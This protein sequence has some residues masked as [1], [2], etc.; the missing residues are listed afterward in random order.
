MIL[1]A[2]AGAWL[3][4]RIVFRAINLVLRLLPRV[5]RRVRPWLGRQG[6]R[7]LPPRRKRI[8]KFVAQSPANDEIIAF[9]QAQQ[10]ERAKQMLVHIGFQV[11]SAGDLNHAA[12]DIDVDAVFPTFVGIEAQRRAAGGGRNR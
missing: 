3:F 1:V 9:N 2:I 11:L 6:V 10:I 7:L 5:R 4:I 12:G 8:S